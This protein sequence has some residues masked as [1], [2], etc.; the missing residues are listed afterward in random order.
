LCKHKIRHRDDAFRGREGQKTS[1]AAAAMT[2][3]DYSSPARH[4]S[5]A[6]SNNQQRFLRLEFHEFLCR[7]KTTQH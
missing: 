6:L 2:L 7:C 5:S 3:C 1:A 4:S